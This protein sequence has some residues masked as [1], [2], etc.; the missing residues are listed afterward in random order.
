MVR[1]LLRRQFVQILLLFLLISVALEFFFFNRASF[2]S[3]FGT[4]RQSLTISGMEGLE[5]GGD[6]L[7]RFSGDGPYFLTLT[8]MEGTLGYMHLNMDCVTPDGVSLPFSVSVAPVDEGHEDPYQLPYAACYA[9]AQ[10][11]TYFYVNTYGDV[12]EARLYLSA[13]EG[14]GFRIGSIASQVKVPCFFSWGRVIAVFLLLCLL[15]ALRP[16]SP[17]Y[18]RQWPRRHL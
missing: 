13:E 4:G 18:R 3:L 17:L 2:L 12:S 15:W 16:S 6:G 9:P 1:N 10:S 11:S 7:Y 5:E 8:G 14:T